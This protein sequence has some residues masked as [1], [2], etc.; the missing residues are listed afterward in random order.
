MASKS[1]ENPVVEDHV[2]EDHVE[3]KGYSLTWNSKEECRQFKILCEKMGKINLACGPEIEVAFEHEDITSD[4]CSALKTLILIDEKIK[5]KNKKDNTQSVPEAVQE[6]VPEVVP[7]VKIESKS[8]SVEEECIQIEEESD[9]CVIC[10]EEKFKEEM[11]KGN[12]CVHYVCLGCSEKINGKCPFCRKKFFSENDVRSVQQLG[13]AQNNALDESIRRRNM[14]IYFNRL[15]RRYLIDNTPD[16]SI[17]IFHNRYAIFKDR[18]CRI[19]N[20]KSF[21]YDITNTSRINMKFVITSDFYIGNLNTLRSHSIMVG[22][23]VINGRDYDAAS[24]PIAPLFPFHIDDI[25]RTVFCIQ[26]MNFSTDLVIKFQERD[27]NG[28]M[29]VEA[30]A[31]FTKNTQRIRRNIHTEYRFGRKVTTNPKFIGVIGIN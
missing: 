9:E 20:I 27:V 11:V 4:L 1:V 10:T 25:Q 26:P 12:E 23:G 30:E 5:A 29:T 3:E 17:P 22:R 8:N 13:M 7:E 21:T 31:Y 15:L 18:A 2:V 16:I 6:V 28:S 24:P 19:P 14:Y